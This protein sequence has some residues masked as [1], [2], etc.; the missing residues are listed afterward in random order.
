MTISEFITQYGPVLMSAVEYV[1]VFFVL[2]KK[3]KKISFK[4]ETE[5]LSRKVDRMI[6]ENKSLR[7]DNKVLR[8]QMSTL[9][10]KTTHVRNYEEVIQDEK[11]RN[12]HK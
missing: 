3:I 2:F 6:E 9:I 10:D 5:V 7:E 4:D 11:E 8:R 12:I 1:T